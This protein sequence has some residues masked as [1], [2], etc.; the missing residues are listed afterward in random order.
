MAED[1]IVKPKEKT[2]FFDFLLRHSK[3]T[4]VVVVICGLFVSGGLVGLAL[5]KSDEDP[6]VVALVGDE[7][8][9]LQDY[10][11]RFQAAT[12][13]FPTQQVADA[14]SYAAEQILD[15]LVRE[16]I[17][18]KELANR[19]LNVTEDDIVAAAKEKFP[20]YESVEGAKQTNY[21]TLASKEAKEAVLRGKVAVQREGYIIY[22]RFDRAGQDDYKV[23][24]AEA[25][26]LRTKQRTYAQ[27]YCT[28]LKERLE[29]G[30]DPKAELRAIEGDPVIGKEPW[31]P[32]NMMFGTAF[33][34]NNFS[35]TMFIPYS[36]TFEQILKIKPEK[37]DSY[38]TLTIKDT[39]EFGTKG[40]E[41]MF[42]ILYL[43]NKGSDG[44]TTDFEKWLEGKFSE[45]KI[46]KYPERIK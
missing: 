1:K 16:K 27:S 33:K 31:K 11:D 37:D 6:S 21:R 3:K 38:N 2:G 41:R 39:G 36:D 46:K 18:E 12:F 9:Y 20:E 32:Y 7:K 5:L 30:A 25:E 4:I 26:A 15:D 17:L 44:E 23:K 29:G 19:E 14:K 42:A 40:Q 34:E 24:S 22:C 8:I 43:K 10:K 28:G 45:Y 13:G 35:K